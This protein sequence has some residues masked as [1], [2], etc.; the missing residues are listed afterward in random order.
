MQLSSIV[1]TCGAIVVLAF[2]GE[3]VGAG[4]QGCVCMCLNPF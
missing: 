3:R 4:K 1:V 2:V